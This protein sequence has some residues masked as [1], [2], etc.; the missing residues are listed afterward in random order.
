MRCSV[1]GCDHGAGWEIVDTDRPVCD[2]CLE[3]I[4]E[5]TD[6]AIM[7]RHL[8]DGGDVEVTPS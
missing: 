6:L 7:V 5:L 4:V 2:C 8:G 1:D 3:E